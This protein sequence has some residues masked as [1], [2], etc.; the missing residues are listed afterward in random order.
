[1]KICGVV[2]EYNPFHNGHAYHIEQ[3]RQKTNADLVIA[4]M[5]GNYLQRGEFAITDKWSR[6]EVAAHYGVDL[7]FELPFYYAVQ[8]ADYFAKGAIEMLAQLGCDVICFGTDGATDFDY[9]RYGRFFKMH[10][11]QIDTMLRAIKRPDWT[12]AKKMVHILTQLDPTLTFDQTQPNHILALSYAKA[13]AALEH[14]MELVAI[15]RKQAGYH[16]QEISSTIASATAIRKALAAK[17]PIASVVPLE[18]F[19]SLQQ[20]L[21]TWEL[22]YPYLRYQLLTTP[23]ETLQTIY[24]MAD[25]M[26]HLLVQAAK[27]ETSFAG[28]LE[29][30]RSKSYPVTKVQRMCLYAFVHMTTK[31]YQTARTHAFFRPLAYTLAGKHYLKTI[32]VHIPLLARFG[33][34]EAEHHALLVRADQLY[35]L[36]QPTVL[37]QNFGRFPI[38]V[39]T[40][41]KS[42]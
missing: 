23:I 11:D 41:R 31:E 10:Q 13:N 18:M 32:K 3:A 38:L 36:I 7:V 42:V 9:T 19:G 22:A 1:M 27:K 37:E 29:T 15:A 20:D 24:Q 5:S 17:R 16:D 39:E 33:K 26:E 12:Y 34:K 14:P 8:S 25:G 35:Q 2:V 30:V 4:V 21:V 28:F 6:A 40:P